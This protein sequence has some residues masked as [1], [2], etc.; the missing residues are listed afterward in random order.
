MSAGSTPTW[1]VA[2]LALPILAVLAAITKAEV[3]LSSS[4]D[5]RFTVEGFDPRDPLRGH[6]IRFSVDIQESDVISQC[7]N[8]DSDC[9]YCLTSVGVNAPPR[10]QRDTCEHARQS[11]EGAVRI[12]SIRTLRRYYIP[13][14]MR[15]EIDYRMRDAARLGTAE[16]IV[17]V[18]PS[19][20]A[21]VK[22]L[23]INGE[24]ID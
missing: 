2:L 8:H 23:Q 12:K 14:S 16:V 9:C 13:E 21:R 10:I 4:D 19:G 20:T 7:E 15:H 5:W 22:Q 6:Y 18:D 11:C 3:N 1:R 24:N 17:A